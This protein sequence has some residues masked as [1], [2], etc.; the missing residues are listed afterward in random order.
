[1]ASPTESGAAALPTWR[2]HR[3]DPPSELGR[4]R[5]TEP[6]N[7][8]AY[9][10]GHIGWLITR[11]ALGRSVLG[12][13]RFSARQ[14]LLRVPA[15]SPAVHAPFFEAF[16][17]PA[18]P[19]DFLRMDPPEHTRY[20][21]LL[22]G[23]FTMRRMTQL[24]PRIEEVVRTCLDSLE[25]SGSPA[26]LVETFAAPVSS[27]VICELLDIPAAQREDFGRLI[28]DMFSREATGAQ[29]GAS[30]HAIRAVVREVIQYRRA[31]PDSDLL[32]SLAGT[33]EFTDDE[34]V[35]AGELLITAGHETTAN[36]LALG[37]YALLCEPRQWETLRDDPSLIDNAVEE[38]LRYLTIFQFGLRRTA[39]EDVEV[40]GRLI[41]A[42]D[43]VV[44]ST[45]IANRDQQA[46][47]SPDDLDVTRQRTG[48]LAF[49]HG[50]H[51]CLGQHLARVEM[52]VGYSALIDRFPLLRLAAE[53]D[54]IRLGGVV[55]GPEKLPVAW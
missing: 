20:R 39:L 11:Y 9:S 14:D 33:S 48:H 52:R 26:D 16:T 23:H 1:M 43:S 36:M 22:A 13:D 2:S 8:L 24:Q 44:V 7:R 53:P 45:P 27:Y 51:M 15:F 35:G 42:G 40:A 46:F 17:G 18:H 5:E 19:G 21:R 31:N 30:R 10:D 38:L 28:K 47:E 49:G 29:V 55:Y 34:V 4:L 3:L 54:E 12:D 32:S 37:T 41:R 25:R 50:V 6:I